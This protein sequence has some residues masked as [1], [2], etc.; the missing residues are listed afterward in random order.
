MSDADS[1]FGTTMESTCTGCFY[2]QESANRFIVDIF[3]KYGMAHQDA[4][5]ILS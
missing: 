4:Q 1:T 5:V 3:H 2:K